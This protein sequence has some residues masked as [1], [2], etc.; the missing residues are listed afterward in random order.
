MV[1]ISDSLK[2]LKQEQGASQGEGAKTPSSQQPF[3]TGKESPG[4]EEKRRGED[5]SGESAKDHVT[6]IEAMKQN[7]PGKPA[8]AHIHEIV[9]KAMPEKGEG[10]NIYNEIVECCR[11]MTSSYADAQEMEKDVIVNIAGKIADHI[12]L[13]GQELLALASGPY[14][15]EEDYRILDLVNTGIIAGY[16]SSSLNYNKSKLMEVILTGLFHEVGV[17]KDLD[18][19]REARKLTVEEFHQMREHPEKSASYLQNLAAFSEEVIEGV[20]YHHERM[21]GEGYPQGLSGNVIS[22]YAQIVAVAD[23][24]EALIH[25]RPHKN[26]I[27]S[28]VDAIKDLIIHKDSLFNQRILKALIETIGIYPIG[29]WVELNSGEIC[30]VLATNEEFPLRPVCS[31]AF[32]SNRKRLDEMQTIDLKLSPSLYIKRPVEESE[33]KGQ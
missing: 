30:R 15:E 5:G 28:P 11:K 27:L 2:K 22:E 8:K 9:K 31:V 23:V 16:I 14:A 12:L 25:K 21:N 17:F 26:R 20:L 19:L 1:R 18:F 4:F 7:E 29:S 10:Q 13:G 33:L 3:K 6:F 24:Y 32:D